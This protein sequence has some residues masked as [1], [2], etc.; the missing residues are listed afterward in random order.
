MQTDGKKKAYIL[1]GERL[2]EVPVDFMA[3][4]ESDGLKLEPVVFDYKKQSYVLAISNTGY[5]G[6]ADNIEQAR[7]LF[8]IPVPSHRIIYIGNDFGW[9]M[10]PLPEIK[11]VGKE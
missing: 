2:F 7:K 5:I 10:P 9:C 6:L 8:G 11:K 4:V 1:K 3:V